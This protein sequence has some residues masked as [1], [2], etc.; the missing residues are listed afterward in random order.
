[1]IV[2]VLALQGAFIEHQKMLEQLGVETFQIRNKSHLDKP[3]D[4]IVLPGGESTTMYRVL[5]DQ[6]MVEPLKKIINDGLPTFGTCAGL[7]LLAKEVD[8]YKSEYLQTMDIEAKKNAYGRQLGSFKTVGEFNGQKDTPFVF[9]RAPY[10]VETKNDNVEVLAIVDDK[11]V[12]ARQNNQFVTAFHS[13]LTDDL[14]V[15]KFFV[16]MLK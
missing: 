16:D 12:A 14:T 11:I 13:E 4:G 15:H 6:N 2:G 1:M 7:L 10:I 9:I 3:M 8:N 5:R